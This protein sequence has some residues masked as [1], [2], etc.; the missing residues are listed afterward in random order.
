MGSSGKSRFDRAKRNFNGA[1]FLRTRM[2]G[3]VGCLANEPGPTSMGPGSFEPGWSAVGQEI[4]QHLKRLQWGRVPSN[5]DGS[6]PD[7]RRKAPPSDFN[8]AGFLRTRMAVV[9]GAGGHELHVLQWG[10]VPSNPDGGTVEY[11]GGAT[12]VTSMGPG[13][14]EPGWIARQLGDYRG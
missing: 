8:G 1:G 4:N 3:F 5:P 7:R 11:C 9:A 10:R 2:A 6:A 13:S 14:F 12:W